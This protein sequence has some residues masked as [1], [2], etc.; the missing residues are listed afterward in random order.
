MGRVFKYAALCFLFL[1]SYE[2]LKA[3]D[4]RWIITYPT[5]TNAWARR[6]ASGEN[7]TVM[8]LQFID[9]DG[10]NDYKMTQIRVRPFTSAASWY[11][12]SLELWVNTDNYPGSLDRDADSLISSVAVVI[13]V[14][15]SPTNPVAFTLPDGV[16]LL[17]DTTTFFVAMVVQDW[18]TADPE[19]LEISNQHGTTIGITVEKAANDII[20]ITTTDDYSKTANGWGGDVTKLFQIQAV[21]LPVIIYNRDHSAEEDSNMFFPNYLTLDESDESKA[22]IL[23]DLTFTAHVFLP[24]VNIVRGDSLSYASFK[25]GWNNQYLELDSIAF[26]DLWD[27]KQY[28]ENG[29][30]ESGYGV[31]TLPGDTNY[32]VVRF[33]AI[34]IGNS[35][36]PQNY[37]PI[38]NNS[39]GE[40]YFKVL[41]PG[42]SPLFLADITLLDQWG[43][44]YHCYRQLQNNTDEADARYDAW[45]KQ[46][47]GDFCGT[48]DLNNGHCDA[49][50]DP[51]TDI[52]LFADHLWLN[53]DSAEWYYRF[54]IGDSSSHDPD[55][56]APD[57]TTN[58]FD[59]MVIAANYYR[60]LSG[61]FSQ[62]K[63]SYPDNPVI[64]YDWLETV[65]NSSQHLLQLTMQNISQLVCGHLILKF[66]PAE[67]EFCSIEA[68]A[69]VDQL[70]PQ[71]IWLYSPEQLA[72]GYLDINFVALGQPLYGEGEFA[73]INFRQKTEIQP[74]IEVS[75]VDLRDQ[76]CQQIQVHTQS[77]ADV[78]SE[79]FLM[80]C[81]PNP[82]N[83]STELRY[84]IPIGGAGQYCIAIYDLR[85]RQVVE[86]VNQYHQV[87][88]YQLTWNGLN[89]LD[90]PVA[91]GVYIVR[92]AGQAI[93][94]NYKITL[95]R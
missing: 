18:R 64:A 34:V 51:F 31:T 71:S 10:N 74:A 9:L 80:D 94:K 40:F 95:I 70:A 53:P 77:L 57:D 1:F 50:V 5:A 47:P 44:P 79:I 81:Y 54:D 55:A 2:M 41:K 45:S 49:L 48:I 91:S 12:E 59:L 84:R 6:I 3:E 15:S 17:D 16:W 32:S 38:A 93:N 75:L 69:R 92:V 78:A 8:K 86:L 60:T 63:I 14:Q 67:I 24:H 11:I 62:K 23:T 58:F 42:I 52:S 56:L 30:D 83:P 72:R 22:Q 29:W 68:G 27:D 66:N 19:D 46:I 90:V 88:N 39:L 25:V 61:E 20:V 7:K 37:V 28:Q 13:A 4:Y 87:G 21:N 26:G 73:R 76:N 82:F 65:A 85:G 35:S 89:Q 36:S 43:I 33:E